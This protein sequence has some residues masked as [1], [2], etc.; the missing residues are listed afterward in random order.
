MARKEGGAWRG[1]KEGGRDVSRR[2]GV[3]PSQRTHKGGEVPLPCNAEELAGQ[4]AALLAPS[5]RDP[6][7]SP[8]PASPDAQLWSSGPEV[9]LSVLESPGVPG[10]S[11]PMARGKPNGPQHRLLQTTRAASAHSGAARA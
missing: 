3:G 10:G 5:P 11:S 8:K 2:A 9:D 7:R 4:G 1:E 6:A